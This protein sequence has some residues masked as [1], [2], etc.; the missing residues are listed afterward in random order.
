MK[1]LQIK[2]SGKILNTGF[3]FFIKQFAKYYSICGFVQYTS[4][5][6]LTI[7]AEGSESNLNKFIKFC[8][9]GPSDSTIIGFK[10][11]EGEIQNHSSFN[12]IENVTV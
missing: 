8:R 11:T 5:T 3:L 7:E 9:T 12:I 10:I 4:D 6:S 1:N 2:I